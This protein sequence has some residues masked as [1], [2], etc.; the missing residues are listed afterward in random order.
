MAGHNVAQPRYWGDSQW[1]GADQP[2]VGVSWYEAEAYAKWAG[3]RLPTEAEWEAA[4]R[5]GPRS[6]GYTYAGSNDLGSVA[7]YRDNSG[8]V[9]H[10]VKGKAPNELGLYDMS[11]NVWE[12]VADCY[13]QNYYS[14]T[15]GRNPP[16]PTSGSDR[17]L[18]GG[19]WGNYPTY[20]RCAF[21]YG[22]GPGYRF[23]SVGFRVAQ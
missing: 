22:F 19:S 16:D 18:R 6:R 23:S 1:N 4:A 13:D 17:V 20:V 14:S 3:G 5:G 12:W 11:G 2:V 10:A 7:W 9:A 21:R 8:G 15:P